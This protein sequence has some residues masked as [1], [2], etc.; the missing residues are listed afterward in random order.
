MFCVSTWCVCGV[1]PACSVCST[2][3]VCDVGPVCPVCLLGVFVV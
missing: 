1:G 3:C 2:W